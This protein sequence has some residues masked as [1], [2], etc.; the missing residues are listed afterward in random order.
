MSNQEAFYYVNA[1]NVEP[2]RLFEFLDKDCR[3]IATKS[4]KYSQVDKMFIQAEI[5]KLLKEGIIEEA[6]S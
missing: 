5:N 6:T 1:A 3:P 4:R 2:P